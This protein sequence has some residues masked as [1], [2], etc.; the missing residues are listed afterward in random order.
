MANIY[1]MFNVTRRSVSKHLTLSDLSDNEILQMTRFPRHAVSELCE[2]MED[3]LSRNTARSHAIPVETQLLAALQFF[4]SGSFQWMIGRSC[5]L[6]QSS[7]SHCIN[8]VTEALVKMAP[9]FI[10]YPTDE[11]TLRTMKQSFHAVANFPNVIGAIDCTHVAIK[12]P[13]ANEEAFVNR[14]GVHTVNVQAVCNADMQLLDVVAKW[15]GSSHDSF[16]WR[17]S[18]LHNM[19]ERGHVQGGWLLGMLDR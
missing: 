8:D 10:S 14:K 11:Q 3:E 19:F 17:S 2:M 15:P 13:T 18:G 9:Q 16:I 6:S 1:L 5:A 4:A 7:V 12:A